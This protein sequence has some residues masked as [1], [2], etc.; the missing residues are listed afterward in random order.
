MTLTHFSDSTRII[1]ST[2]WCDTAIVTVPGTAGSQRRRGSTDLIMH[3]HLLAEAG[4][5]LPLAASAML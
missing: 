1:R 3:V 2:T 4:F 5:S